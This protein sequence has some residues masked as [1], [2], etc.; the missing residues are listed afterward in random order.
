MGPPKIFNYKGLGA[1]DIFNAA[2]TYIHIN[3]YKN[4]KVIPPS[5]KF[6]LIARLAPVGNA[7]DFYIFMNELGIQRTQFKIRNN[8]EREK[9]QQRKTN[10]T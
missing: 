4:R 3:L 7:P 2:Y 10:K 5:L 9:H 6:Y 8:I 1:I